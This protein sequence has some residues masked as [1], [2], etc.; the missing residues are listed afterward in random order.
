MQSLYTHI[1]NSLLLL[2]HI[3]SILRWSK[4]LPAISYQSTVRRDALHVYRRFGVTDAASHVFNS[5][6]CF[7]C[8]TDRYVT[9]GNRPPLLRFKMAD[10]CAV[11]GFRDNQYVNRWQVRG[12][13][14]EG[15]RGGTLSLTQER[16]WSVNRGEYRLEDWLT[17]QCHWSCSPRC[18]HI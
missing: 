2:L 12:R 6:R 15:P 1:I 5:M 17:D 9:W 14:L 10:I 7:D 11:D 18:L 4:A 8:V 3:W 16:Q 13:L